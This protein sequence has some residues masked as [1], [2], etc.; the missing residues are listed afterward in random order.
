MTSAEGLEMHDPEF[1]STTVLAVRRGGKTAIGGDGQVS[2]GNTVIKGN[3][4]KLRRLYKDRVIVGFA[5]AVGDAFSLMDKFDGMLEKYQGNMAK[6]A[7]EL[8]KMWRTDKYLR[9]LEALMIAADKEKLLL[10]SGTGE[11]IE[12]DEGVAGIGSGGTY[13]VAAAKALM[14]HTELDARRIVEE[15]LK[16]AAKLCV[17]TNDQVQVEVI[18]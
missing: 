1:H 10:I 16:I 17:Y 18:G 13:A 11:V 9:Q 8:A 5:G 3:A 12:P 6:A 15:S 2:M 14:A 7:V 4:L